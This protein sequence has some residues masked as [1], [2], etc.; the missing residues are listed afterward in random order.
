MVYYKDVHHMIK[1]P[2]EVWTRVVGYFRPYTAMNPGKKSE[3][4]ER[5]SFKVPTLDELRND[6]NN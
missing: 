5:V 1:I 6:K 4:N 3:H 2:C